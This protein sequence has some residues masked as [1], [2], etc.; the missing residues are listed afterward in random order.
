M[1][2]G[3]RAILEHES[4]GRELHLFEKVE[5]GYYEY[6]GQFRYDSHKVMQGPDVDGRTRGQILFRLRLLDEQK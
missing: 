6:L 3:D 4:T 2:R 1:I 5:K